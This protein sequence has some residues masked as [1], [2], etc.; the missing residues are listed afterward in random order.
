MTTMMA[1]EDWAR[2]GTSAIIS[3]NLFR[4]QNDEQQDEVDGQQATDR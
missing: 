3:W 2:M 4:V 1:T